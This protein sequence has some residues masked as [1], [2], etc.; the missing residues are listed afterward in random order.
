MS[1]RQ[2]LIV[3]SLIFAIAISSGFEQD[4]RAAAANNDG[5]VGPATQNN[6]KTKSTAPTSKKKKKGNL[7]KRNQ[8]KIEQAEQAR[9]RRE[10]IKT[11]MQNNNAETGTAPTGR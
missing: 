1:R 11:E 10:K 9:L 8:A 6:G 7:S 4:V 2:L 5:S 3:V